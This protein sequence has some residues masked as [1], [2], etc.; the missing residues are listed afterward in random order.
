MRNRIV[1]FLVGAV[2]VSVLAVVGSGVAIGAMERASGTSGT[3][4]SS[5]SQGTTVFGVTHIFIRQD[6][7]SPARI[8]VVLGTTVTWT[9]R[10]N[11]SHSVVISPEVISTND[12]WQSRLLSTGDSFSYTFTMRGTFQYHCSE[13]PEMTGTVIVT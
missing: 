9:N 2:L 5:V 7:Y 4:K 8:Q 3:V 6:A 13:H 1:W 10:D 11:V 12:M